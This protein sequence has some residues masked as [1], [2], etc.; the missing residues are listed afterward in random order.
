MNTYAIILA[1]GLGKRMGADQSKL[2]L[3]LT[4]KPLLA[5]TLETFEQCADIQGVVLVV[6]A[7]SIDEVAAIAKD[8]QKIRSTVAGGAERQDSVREGLKAVP[9]ETDIIAVHDGARPLV[10]ASEIE[11]A[12]EAARETGAAV[13]GQ[14]LSDT[15]KRVDRGTVVETL[16][17][18]KLWAV[19]TP[20]VFQSDVIRDAHRAAEADGFVGTDDTVLVERMGKCV[21][22]VE[23][24]RDNIKVT[25]PGDLERAEDIYDRRSGGIV[26]RI[27]LGYDVHQLVEGRRLILGGVDIPF[28]FGLEGHSDADVLSHVVIDALLGAAGLGDIGRLFPDTD[29]AFKGISSLVL[30]KRTAEALTDANVSI[31]N[32]DATVM[33]QRPR[34]EPNIAEME[35]NIAAALDISSDRISVKATTTEK[36][37]FV[38]KEEGMAAQAVAIVEAGN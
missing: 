31:G 11:A 2:F 19:Q 26:Q 5:H 20:Q 9:D 33:A 6:P 12:I 4:G 16:D 30:L 23:G 18:S 10:L 34:L 8:F 22:V 17:R 37:G 3:Q 29:D 32:I 38:G 35:A 13:V 36:L 25:H 21:S 14:P 24:S 1:A 15:I 28:E 7:D 27:G